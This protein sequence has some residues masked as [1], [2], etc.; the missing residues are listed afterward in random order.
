MALSVPIASSSNIVVTVE[1]LVPIFKFSKLT[2]PEP[3]AFI[4]KFAFEAFVE[5]VLSVIVTPSNVLAPVT[6]NVVD[7]VAAPV[8]ANVLPSKLK[9]PSAVIAEVPVPVRTALSVKL[10]APVL[11]NL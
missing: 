4:S 7:T 8:T 2:V 5:I 6:P 10:E 9:F 3:F 1:P 11:I